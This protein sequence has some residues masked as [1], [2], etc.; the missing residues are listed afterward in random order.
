M[1]GNFWSKLSDKQKESYKDKALKSDPIANKN[2]TVYDCFGRDINVVEAERH[3]QL[4]EYQA[5]KDEIAL[6]LENANDIG[7]N[8]D[9]AFADNNLLN[10]LLYFRTRLLGFLL[11]QHLIVL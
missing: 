11:Y 5:M 6:M 8:T 9:I 3:K 4:E 10:V 2:R 1:A 7:G